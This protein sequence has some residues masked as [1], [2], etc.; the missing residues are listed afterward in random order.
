MS[1]AQY[2]FLIPFVFNLSAIPFHSDMDS[3]GLNDKFEQLLL[4]KFVPTWMLSE[5]ECDSLPAEFHPGNQ[6]PQLLAKNGTIYGQVFPINLH[7]RSGAYIEIHH[8]HLWSR[9]CGLNGHPLDAEHVSV[10]LSADAL[11][12]SVSEWNAEY[13]YAAAHEDT[14]C[15]ASHA[16]RSSSLN[17][18]QRGPTVWISAGKHASFLDKSL[19]GSGCGGDDCSEMSPIKITKIVNLGEPGAPMNGVLWTQ[20]SGWPLAAKMEPDFSETALAKLDA[21]DQTEMIPVNDS[22]S[23]VKITVLVG[24]SSAEAMIGTNNKTGAALSSA[25]NAVGTSLNKSKDRTGNFLIRAARGVWEALAG[26][27]DVNPNKEEPR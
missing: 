1:I 8:Y 17:T 19:C 10:L 6:A 22:R 2:L 21:A 3:D 23:S 27:N 18:V 24:T 7:G 16:A 4:E 13:W 14:V 25:S 15:D 20:W 5:K 26:G 12:D 9:D 11:V